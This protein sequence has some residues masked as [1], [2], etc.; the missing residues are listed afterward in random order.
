MLSMC[1]LQNTIG[2][3]IKQQSSRECSE[4]PIEAGSSIHRLNQATHEKN[5]G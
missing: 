3:V 2:G 1:S 5:L 4:S